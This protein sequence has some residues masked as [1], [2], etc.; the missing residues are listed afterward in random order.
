[1][2]QKQ[3]EQRASTPGVPEH[4]RGSHAKNLN[5]QDV[6]R[7]KTQGSLKV[8]TYEVDRALDPAIRIVL[9]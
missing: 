3:I 2:L 6:S 4:G 8:S 5:M 9:S 7:C 1:M